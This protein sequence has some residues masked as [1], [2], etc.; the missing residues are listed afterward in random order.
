MKSYT[1]YR[2]HAP[3]GGAVA[4]AVTVH[5]DGKEPRPLAPRLDLRRH[6]VTGLEWGFLG[7]GP[8]QLALALAADA[9]GDDGRARDVYQ[10]LKFKLVARLPEDGWT[11]TEDQ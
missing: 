5:E 7:S 1:G 2:V 10:K 8:A 3:G 4:T 6:S 9:L 11:V